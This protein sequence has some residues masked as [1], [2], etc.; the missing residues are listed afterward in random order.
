[1]ANPG[2]GGGWMRRIGWR[3]PARMPHDGIPLANGRFGALLWGEGDTLR[4]T[5]N[6][7]DFWDHRGGFAWTPEVNYEYI[8]RLLRARDNQGLHALF[9]HPRECTTRLPMG[10]VD[11]RLGGAGLE[12][13]ALELDTATAEVRTGGGILWATM[14]QDRPVLVVGL[15][16]GA[17]PEVTAVPA[18][19]GLPGSRERPPQTFFTDNGYAPP[20]PFAQAGECGWTFWRPDGEPALAVVCRTAPGICLVTAVYGPTPDAALSAGRAELDAVLARREGCV[21]GTRAW[22]RRFWAEG[23]RIDVP[24]PEVMDLYAL[25]MYKAACLGMAGG[26]GATLQGAWVEEY[27]MP[28]WSADYHFNINVQ[29]CYWPVCPANHPELLLPLFD[30]V[31]SW[32]GRLREYARTFVGVEDGRMLPHAVNDRCDNVGGF[33]TGSI[34]HGSTAWVGQLMWTYYRHTLDDGFLRERAYPFLRGAMRVYEAM[35]EDDGAR[36]SLP[37]SVSPE[38][39]G[40]ADMAWGP[41]ASFQ[42]YGVHFLCAALLAASERL[43]VDPGQRARWRDIQTRL[44]RYAEGP[45]GEIAP[46]EGQPLAESHRHHS[47]LSGIHPWDTLDVF[48]ADAPVVRRSLRTWVLRGTGAWTGWCVPWAAILHARAGH[49]DMAETLLQVFARAF[50]TQGHGSLHD[51]NFPGFT[52]FDGRR[53]VMQV[54]AA[55]GFAAAVQEMLL[56]AAGGVLQGFP[57]LPSRWRQ[58]HFEGLRTEGAV[59]ASGTWED[60][61]LGHLTFRAEHAGTVR[62]RLSG[63]A[64]L[65]TGTL[66]RG[67]IGEIALGAGQAVRV[68]P[69]TP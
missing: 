3:F 44:P 43:G 2:A 21:A 61:R 7:S 16:D 5:L 41:N 33:W 50:V 59:L 30:L 68:E 55:I 49:G 18:W 11:L 19:E 27:R 54:E 34:D 62:L 23:A 42:L 57:A 28:P 25:G 64:R 56:H 65:P 20:Q 17:S 22:W 60:G 58:A 63:D 1:M 52:V 24:D 69:A 45:R 31:E 51:A 12:A 67:Q 48:G 37:V 39:G 4:V 13:G 36:L 35:L 9:P 66:P 15:P 29:E 32:E 46:W 40:D 6:R 14:L 47:H 8:T 53:D 38:Y 10:R 26:V